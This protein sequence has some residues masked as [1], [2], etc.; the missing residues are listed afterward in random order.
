MKYENTPTMRLCN[1]HNLRLAESFIS[2]D[3]PTFALYTDPNDE[4]FNQPI[5]ETYE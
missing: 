2:D 3:E 1:Q 5:T 4:I